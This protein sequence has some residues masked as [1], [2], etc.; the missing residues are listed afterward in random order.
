MGPRSALT[1]ARPRSTIYAVAVIRRIGSEQQAPPS[2][3]GPS[4]APP[5]RVGRLTLSAAFGLI[6]GGVGGAAMVGVAQG[7][8]H[9]EHVPTAFLSALTPAALRGL[10]PAQAPALVAA[11]LAGA[12]VGLPLG[13][14]TRRLLR[15]LPRVLFFALFM[16]AAWIGIQALIIPHVAPA[17]SQHLP[18]LPLC[19]GA[20]AYGLCLALA[21][22]PAA[23]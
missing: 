23:G 7:L 12:V 6:A 3:H 11:A 17:L 13:L 9:L 8:A 18:F 1:P 15:L 16:A 5:P 21:R 19:A 14:L 10:G 20:I 4:L 22:P 2:S